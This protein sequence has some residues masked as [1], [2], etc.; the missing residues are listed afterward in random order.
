MT[1]VA[2]KPRS[3]PR[4]RVPQ[5]AVNWE[6]RG[7]AFAGS[8]WAV[9]KGPKA[10]N[11]F[12]GDPYFRDCCVQRPIPKMA[13]L[14]S[15]LWYV[16]LFLIPLPV[17]EAV[18]PK[19]EPPQ[20]EL[21]RIELTWYPPARDLPSMPQPGEPT[22]PSPPGEPEK[23][24]PK[25]GAGAFHPRQSILSSPLKPTHPRQTLI[26]PDAPLQPPKIGRASCRERVYVLV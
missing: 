5:L 10:P 16:V 19:Q 6:S 17:W 18:I 9:M 15:S 12:R 2:V 11:E 22:K 7:E 24:L 25:R 20:L 4:L 14:A 13:M 8:L 21:P 1:E 26:R 3:R 23:P